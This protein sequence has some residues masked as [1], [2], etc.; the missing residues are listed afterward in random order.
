[1]KNDPEQKEVGPIE[2]KNDEVAN[3]V[4]ARL[5][6]IPSHISISIGGEGSFSV[7]ELI[8]RIRANDDVGK[9]FIEM[10]LAYLRALKDL[11][12]LGLENVHSDN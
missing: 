5:Q 9:K 6:T 4:V 12:S 10:Q 3:L 7:E 2:T 11:S 1:M 8:E